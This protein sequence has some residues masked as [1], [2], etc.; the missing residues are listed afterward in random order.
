MNVFKTLSFTF[1]FI[2]L[3]A[4]ASSAQESR[5]RDAEGTLSAG[6]LA[7]T[8]AEHQPA[9]DGQRA[10]LAELL[11]RDDVR[12]AADERDIDLGRLA[13]AAEGLSDAQV[14]AISPLVDSIMEQGGE[15]GLG[16]VTIG[17]GLLIV[18][19]LILILVD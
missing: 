7:T 11:S 6:L 18:I 13:T 16:T 12:A 3:G 2:A 1:L 17:V 4:T 19:L 9:V 10:Q 8:L 15:G 5:T 14:G